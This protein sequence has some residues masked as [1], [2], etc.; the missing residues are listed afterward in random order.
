MKIPQELANSPVHILRGTATSFAVYEPLRP[1]SADFAGLD[2]I[3]NACKE[4]TGSE[5]PLPEVRLTAEEAAILYL[6]IEEHN[7]RIDNARQA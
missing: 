1:L 5:R 3:L 6:A 7:E 4:A 2:E